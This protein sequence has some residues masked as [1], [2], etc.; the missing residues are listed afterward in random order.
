[1][2]AHVERCS[3]ITVKLIKTPDTSLSLKRKHNK[4]KPV[5][6]L[7]AESLFNMEND[8]GG[9]AGKKQKNSAILVVHRIAVHYSL[10]TVQDMEM[11]ASLIGWFKCNS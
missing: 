8:S 4:L 5:S 11:G 7:D 6:F 9:N 3:G 1:M 10:T 2:K